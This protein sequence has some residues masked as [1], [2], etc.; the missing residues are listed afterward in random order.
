MRHILSQ[1]SNYLGDVNALFICSEEKS[2][3][4]MPG[5]YFKYIFELLHQKDVKDY[6]GLMSSEERLD[7][8]YHMAGRLDRFQS[9]F[10]KAGDEFNTNAAIAAGKADDIDFY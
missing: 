10:A 8:F 7:L 6:I 3:C 9:S 5:Q 1:L 2:K 4:P